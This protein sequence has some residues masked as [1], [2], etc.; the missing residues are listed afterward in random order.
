M[1]IVLFGKIR[2]GKDTVGKILIEK[3]G[4]K[5][6]AFGDEIGKIIETYFPKAYIN[7]KPRHHYQ[8]I[9]QKFR[10]LD[11]DVWIN[12]LLEK[13]ESY[14][15]YSCF[16]N[17]IIN[18]N[19]EFFK[20]LKRDEIN[21]VVTDGRQKN[22]AIKMRE[23]GYVIVKVVADEEIRIKRMNESGDNYSP[24]ML[25]HETELQV[26]EVEADYIINNAGTLED[27][28]KIVECLVQ[29]IRKKEGREGN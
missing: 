25:T 26:D 19:L 2:S 27:L 3:Y 21:V 4:F 1:K 14:E 28:E 12:T 17:A 18:A 11:E 7:G 5:R 29:Q 16:K 15:Y 20:E 13:V 9:G 23:A 8:F 6:F 10:E 24:E 22:E